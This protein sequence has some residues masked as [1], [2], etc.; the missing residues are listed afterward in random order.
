[1]RKTVTLRWL[2]KECAC[3]AGRLAFVN[4]FG[5]GGR[6]EVREVLEWLLDPGFDSGDLSGDLGFYCRRRGW[7]D[8]QSWANWL[9]FWFLPEKIRPRFNK[10]WN[11]LERKLSDIGWVFRFED[12]ER[13]RRLCFRWLDI[14][15]KESKR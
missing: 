2:R 5:V 7:R 14:A 4:R 8:G 6:P 3:R 9:M 12:Q 11:E 10:A 1:M 13:V 15:E